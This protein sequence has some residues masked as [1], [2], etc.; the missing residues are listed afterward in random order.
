MPSNDPPAAA[1][2]RASLAKRDRPGV[3]VDTA[4]DTTALSAHDAASR[5]ST[6]ASA[7][8]P[9]PSLKKR[10]TMPGSRGVANLTPEQLA[11]KRANGMFRP[12]TIV[13]GS[14]WVV[15][16]SARLSTCSN[17]KATLFRTLLLT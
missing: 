14:V 13:A 3:D 2:A 5:Q 17:T 4:V 1:T 12:V 8:G 9:E 7:N 11:K 10:K 16:C 15:R 6:P